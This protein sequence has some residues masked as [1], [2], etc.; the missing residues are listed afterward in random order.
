MLS[1]FKD[2]KYR[3]SFFKVIGFSIIAG[4]VIVARATGR[5]GRIDETTIYVFL[6]IV[7]LCFVVSLFV[8]NASYKKRIHQHKKK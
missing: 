5:H 4:I 8:L 1:F 6:G 7:V 2:R 3:N